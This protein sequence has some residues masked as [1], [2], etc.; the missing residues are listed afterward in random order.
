MELNIKS[1]VSEK[2]KSLGLLEVTKYYLEKDGIINV[3]CEDVNFL[4]S[5]K[6]II[7]YFYGSI[8]L[9]EDIH[10]NF[11]KKEK[12]NTILL[13]E[14]GQSISLRDV[15]KVVNSVRT[16]LNDTNIIYGA[17]I[18]DEIVYNQ[19]RVLI[20]N[21]IDEAKVEVEET[22][23]TVTVNKDSNYDIHEIAKICKENNNYSVNFIQTITNFG[24]NKSLKIKTEVLELINK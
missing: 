18:N 23:K 20:I 24:F 19:A 3:D 13:I 10:F 15:E 7:N 11:V 12:S 16:T 8:N 2:L 14:S 21:T 1:E 5:G 9:R 4:I 6:K 17:Y 22:L